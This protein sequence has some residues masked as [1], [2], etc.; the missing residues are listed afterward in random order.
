M[1]VRIFAA[2]H[3]WLE[4]V[5]GAVEEDDS[6]GLKNMT[7]YDMVFFLVDWLRRNGYA[8]YSICEVVLTSRWLSHIRKEIGVANVFYSHVQLEPFVRSGTCATD[9]SGVSAICNQRYS[10]WATWT[11]TIATAAF[12][13]SQKGS[14]GWTTLLSD[15]AD[16]TSPRTQL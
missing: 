14:G 12:L 10:A 5:V 8:G 16:P 3:Y 15:S 4:P 6:W 7:G 1:W 11:H 13:R 2:R 9:E